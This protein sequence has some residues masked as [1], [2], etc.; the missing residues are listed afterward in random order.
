MTT[1]IS[2]ETLRTMSDKELAAHLEAFKLDV[3]AAVQMLAEVFAENN[4]R[5][6]VAAQACAFMEDSILEYLEDKMGN[7]DAQLEVL[8]KRLER[9]ESGDSSNVVQFRTVQ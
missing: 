5:P 4:V 2:A 3:Q 9:I 8:K 1:I 6:E 7:V